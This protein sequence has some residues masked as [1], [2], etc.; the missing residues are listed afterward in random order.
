L[1]VV[2]KN[3]RERER[4]KEIKQSNRVEKMFEKWKSFTNSQNSTKINFIHFQIWEKQNKID[5]DILKETNCQFPKFNIVSLEEKERQV[6][7]WNNSPS[8]RLK[9]IS[10]LFVN[11]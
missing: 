9:Q 3:K 2:K 4:K 11:E 6:H 10:N 1:C 8:N 7:F 5:K